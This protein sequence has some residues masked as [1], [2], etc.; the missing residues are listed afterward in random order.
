MTGRTGT[1]SQDRSR[2]IE[3]APGLSGQVKDSPVRPRTERTSPGHSGQVQDRQNREDKSR[4]V[5][6]K[7]KYQSGQVGQ[8]YN[9][10][11]HL[12]FTCCT[13]KCS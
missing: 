13:I 4:T 11:G 9:K 10:Q 2:T 7:K 5:R 1:D 6:R 8:E 12:R 3:T